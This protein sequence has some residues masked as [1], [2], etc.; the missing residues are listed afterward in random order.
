M[1]I[2]S[3]SISPMS[4]QINSQHLIEVFSTDKG[5]VYQCDKSARIIVE[6]GGLQ[7]AFKIQTFMNLKKVIDRIDLN[8]M[9]QSIE[10]AH[11]IEIVTLPQSQSCYV[12]TLC[13]VVHLRELLAGAKVMLELNSILQEKI[14]NPFFVS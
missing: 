11:D 5:S 8:L 14:Y 3:S 6:F 10:T 4:M 2:L 13:D 7:S 1:S 9:I 12:L